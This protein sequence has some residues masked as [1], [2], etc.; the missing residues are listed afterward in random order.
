MKVKYRTV[1]IPRGWVYCRGWFMTKE[2]FRE[3]AR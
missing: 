2:T 3:W 1:K